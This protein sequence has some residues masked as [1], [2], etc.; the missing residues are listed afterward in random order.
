MATQQST[1]PDQSHTWAVPMAIGVLLVVGGVA[2]LGASVMTSVVTVLVIGGML[3]AVGVVEIISA[4]RVRLSGLDLGLLLAGLLAIVIGALFVSRPL[5]S[6]ASV[7]LLIA[8]YMVARG[9]FHIAVAVTDRSRAWI[10][11]LAYGLVALG[12][13]VYVASS[14]QVSSLWL[15]GTFVGIEIIARGC[16]L[17]AASWVIRDME[18]EPLSTR[19]AAT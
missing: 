19:Y 5:A 10:W 14:W 7:T 11:D 12:L 17:I 15:L 8:G 3:F 4:F 18:H 6:L 2:A 16:T 1:D 13:G 9:L